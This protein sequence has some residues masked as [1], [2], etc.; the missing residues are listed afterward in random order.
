VVCSPHATH[1]DVIRAALD[2]DLHVFVEKPLCISIEDADA[3]C[4][5][6]AGGRPVVQVGYMK[7]FSKAYASFLDGLPASPDGLRLIDV[8]TYDPWMAREPFVPWSR[9]TPADD[10]PPDVRA[11]AA[12]HE[13]RQVRQAVGRDDPETVRAY[14]YTFLSCL[15]HDVNLVN[16]VLDRLGLGD[17]AE[18]RESAAW[19]GGDAASAS[20]RLPGGALWRTSWMLL[21][22]LMTFDERARLYFDDAIHEL[23]FPAPYFPQAPITHRIAA[24]AGPADELRGSSFVEEPFVA[25]LEH[26]HDCIVRGDTC[27]TPPQQARRDLALLRDLF[28]TR[29]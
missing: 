22:G 28:L 23:A 4:E 20:L 5:R 21:R 8:V 29:T 11:A 2:R 6:A 24:G 10:V 19:A 27:R 25:E 1:A 15:V 18:P 12:E 14:S 3:I 17:A 7:R 16:G 13:R 26:F 9:M